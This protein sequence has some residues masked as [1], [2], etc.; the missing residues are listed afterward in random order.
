MNLFSG[1]GD[2]K[3]SDGASAKSKKP[4]AAGAD[5]EGSD[6][7]SDVGDGGGNKVGNMP[8][9]DYIIHVLII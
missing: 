5:G 8:E 2:D 9:G 7:G 1:H 3:K 4:D 6:A